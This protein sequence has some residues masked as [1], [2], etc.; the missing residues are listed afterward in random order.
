MARTKTESQV[1]QFTSADQPSQAIEEIRQENNAVAAADA[2]I[3]DSY[4]AI[5]AIGRIE[6]AQFY[7]T[8][9]EKLI[10]ETAVNI[11]ESKQYK[12]LPYKDANGNTKQVSHFEEFC[13]VFLG[14]TARRIQQLMSNYNQLGP[15]LYE[16]AE[17]LGFRQRDYNA[18]KALPS[19]DRQ[20]IAQAIEE[21]NLEKAL[22]ILQEMAAKHVREKEQLTKQ[23]EELTHTLE[24]KD[25]VIKDKTTT[26]DTQAERLALLE[27]K[28]KSVSADQRLIDARNNLQ[29]TAVNLKMEVAS[30]FM[31]QVSDLLAMD[32]GQSQYAAALVIEIK[33]ELD[34]VVGDFNLPSVVDTNQVPEWMRGTEFDPNKAGA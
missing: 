23:T 29:I 15:D 28:Q 34:I 3:M 18:L 32:R 2:V 5:K 16:Q 19:D 10:A 9:S 31:R 7:E 30:R 22:D 33:N 26:I 24:A 12:G 20:L 1:E 6:A 11:R 25:K 13:E 17:R 27:T 4:D 14:K 8:V 21:E